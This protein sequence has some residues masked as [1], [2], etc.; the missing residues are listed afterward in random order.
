MLDGIGNQLIIKIRNRSFYLFLLPAFALIGSLL[1]HN[2][3]TNFDYKPD[4]YS[5]AK[6]SGGK[7]TCDKSNKFCTQNNFFL[8]GRKKNIGNCGKFNN[9]ISINYKSQKLQN[10]GAFNKLSISLIESNLNEKFTL[11]FIND[12][13]INQRCI[14]NS[15]LFFLYKIFPLPFQKI[16]EIKNDK[17]F[18]SATSKAVFPFIYGETSISNIVKRYPV[19]FTFKPLI[20]ISCIYMFLYWCSYNKIINQFYNKKKINKFFIFGFLSALFLFLHTTFLGIEIDNK[21]FKLLKRLLVI[22]FILFEV[23]A[24]YYLIKELYNL[25]ERIKKYINVIFLNLKILLISSVIIA[26]VF[27]LAIL[28]IKDLDSKVDYI[29]EWNYFLILLLYYLFSFL[30]WK[31]VN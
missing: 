8:P 21:I 9:E 23:M 12:G 1:L 14:K 15:S 6:Y 22:F 17:N 26:T 30:M 20:Y 24:Q 25:K 10:L 4:Y 5:T 11:E 18:Q 27:I 29:L 16:Y 3:I 2:Y 19:N 7:F 28:S 31:K 13:Q